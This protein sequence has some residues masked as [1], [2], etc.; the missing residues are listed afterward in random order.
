M[1]V[2]SFSH[3]NYLLL[4]TQDTYIYLKLYRLALIQAD[5]FC[6][7]Y[8]LQGSIVYYTNHLRI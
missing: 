2:L 1:S 5:F 7:T 3:G 6:K 8:L 4:F